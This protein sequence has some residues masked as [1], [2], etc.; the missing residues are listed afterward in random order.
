[1]IRKWQQHIQTLTFSGWSRKG[2]A[3]LASLNKVVTIAR[4]SI[5]ICETA[6]KKSGLTSLLFDIDLLFSENDGEED[7]LE[8]E[9]ELFLQANPMAVFGEVELPFGKLYKEINGSPCCA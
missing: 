2:Y 7:L 8:Y 6:I 5:D 9:N 1:M 3:I 4:L